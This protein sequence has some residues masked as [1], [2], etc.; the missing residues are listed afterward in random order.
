MSNRTEG[1][2]Q[3]AGRLQILPVAVARLGYDADCNLWPHNDIHPLLSYFTE[4]GIGTIRDEREAITWFRK[5]AEHGDKRAITRLRT[6][7]SKSGNVHAA[8]SYASSPTP[9]SPTFGGRGSNLRHAGR[10]LTSFG[11]TNNPSAQSQ[12]ESDQDAPTHGQKAGKKADGDC[13]VS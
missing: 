1:T 9:K 3:V 13:V 12:S 7:T 4:V 5:A 10:R 11:M 8:E 6:L 2:A